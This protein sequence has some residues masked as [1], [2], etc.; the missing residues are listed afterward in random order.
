[1]NILNDKQSKNLWW[2]FLFV[3]FLISP[4]FALFGGK[5]NKKKKKKKE[6]KKRGKKKEKKE[7]ID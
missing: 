5:K 6:N 3:C 1:M 4:V 7:Q 2:G